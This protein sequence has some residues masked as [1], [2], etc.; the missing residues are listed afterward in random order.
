M[1]SYHSKAS[2]ANFLILSVTCWKTT[3]G[4]SHNI[5]GNFCSF[6]RFQHN[7]VIIDA[8]SRDI[9]YA[10]VDFTSHQCSWVRYEH[11]IL[12]SGSA[13]ISNVS[14]ISHYDLASM[15]QPIMAI[16]IWFGPDASSGLIR[17]VQCTVT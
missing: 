4:I 12:S 16:F 2:F 11:S 13:L 15:W 10:E 17:L 1:Q 7:V 8:V 6:N 5:P 3:S 9:L 14:A